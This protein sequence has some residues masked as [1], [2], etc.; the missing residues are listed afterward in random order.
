MYTV[1]TALGTRMGIS[2]HVLM[3]GVT[4]S[5]VRRS[6]VLVSVHPLGHQLSTSCHM[7]GSG[8][9]SID[10]IIGGQYMF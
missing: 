10:Q 7:P 1:H 8:N 9:C 3:Q 5:H 2:L 4:H 6:L